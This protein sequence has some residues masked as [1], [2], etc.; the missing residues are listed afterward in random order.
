MAE[1][2]C[3][4]DVRVQPTAAVARTAAVLMADAARD[5]QLIHVAE[6]RYKEID[7]A[8]LLPAC[9][10]LVPRQVDEDGVYAQLL[11]FQKGRVGAQAGE[12]PSGAVE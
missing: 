12:S 4:I 5:G 9:A 10:A 6:G 2:L 3:A 1:A 8:L 11:R 7:E